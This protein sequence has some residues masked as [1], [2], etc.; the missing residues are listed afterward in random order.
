MI[1]FHLNE[2]VCIAMNID[3]VID[4][5]PPNRQPSEKLKE[6]MEQYR[7]NEKNM[8]SNL[9]HVIYLTSLD[10][11]WLKKKKNKTPKILID[12]DQRT[13][14]KKEKTPLSFRERTPKR[15]FME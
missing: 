5:D 13:K 3:K 6:L 9:N 2:R 11:W 10:G 12:D 14:H 8:N 15:H 1:P 7:E 4:T